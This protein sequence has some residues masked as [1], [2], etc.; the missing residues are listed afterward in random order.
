MRNISGSSLFSRMEL[1]AA[2]VNVTGSAACSRDATMCYESR[3][4]TCRQSRR[5]LTYVDTRR[6]PVHE[7][8][9]A[10]VL[11]DALAA[12]VKDGVDSAFVGM[13][14]TEKV[15]IER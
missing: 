11:E 10:I 6:E 14:D 5:R 13:L 3:V 8:F 4:N 15:F 12:N 9:V 7:C 1:Y 2:L